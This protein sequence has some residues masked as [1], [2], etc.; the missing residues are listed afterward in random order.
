MVYETLQDRDSFIR[1]VDNICTRIA[2]M[3]GFG[4]IPRAWEPGMQNLAI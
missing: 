2:D 3:T 1:G 4:F